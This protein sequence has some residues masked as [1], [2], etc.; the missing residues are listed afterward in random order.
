LEA[1][2]R[3]STL[4]AAILPK[5]DGYGFMFIDR[6]LEYDYLI[7]RLNFVP[8]S[9]ENDCCL[10]IRCS[11]KFYDIFILCLLKT[12]VIVVIISHGLF[13]IVNIFLFYFLLEITTSCHFA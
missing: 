8:D 13:Y 11:Y 1:F 12:R 9:R 7:V 5:L 4:L 6:Y 3:G 2:A 10:F